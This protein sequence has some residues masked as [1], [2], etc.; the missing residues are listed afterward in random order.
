[1]KFENGKWN[2]DHTVS[3]TCDKAGWVDQ[4]DELKYNIQHST[5]EYELKQ[6]PSTTDTDDLDVAKDGFWEFTPD[7]GTYYSHVKISPKKIIELLEL[8]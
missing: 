5:L 3:F 7:R 4:G 2:S 1:M 8:I 6:T